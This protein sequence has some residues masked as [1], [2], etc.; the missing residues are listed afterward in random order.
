MNYLVLP[1]YN[2]AYSLLIYSGNDSEDNR[3]I[4]PNDESYIAFIDMMV[5]YNNYLSGKRKAT[6]SFYE[7]LYKFKTALI[8]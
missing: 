4:D 5:D 1:R 3:F 2:F 8:R 6:D 7:S